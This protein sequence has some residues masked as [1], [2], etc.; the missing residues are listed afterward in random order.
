MIIVDD[1]RWV[2]D[3]ITNIVDWKSLGVEILASLAD[4]VDA[5][6]FVRSAERSP[7]I[8]L[9]DI[10]MPGM[11]GLELLQR[12]RDLAPSCH[13]IILSG[14]RDFEYARE[15]IHQ[16]VF[17]YVLKPVGKEEI[18]DVVRRL[19]A[20]LAQE[21]VDL[22]PPEAEEATPSLLVNRAIRYIEEH[23]TEP[24]GLTDVAAALL[25]SSA[26]LSSVFAETKGQ[27]FK[28]FLTRKKMQAAKEIWR[29]E[30][31]LRVYELCRRVGYRDTN[32]FARIFK[33]V[34][35]VTPR[36]FKAGAADPAPPDTPDG[37]SRA[38]SR[39]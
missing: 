8:C 14:Y 5:L 4:G 12:M 11:S 28:R 32:Y 6:D 39:S 3:G 38:P 34:E 27:T 19:T 7:D 20:L 21:R 22:A 31:Y 37:P 10:R 17:E 30:P 24:I 23:V 9:T 36:E 18:T 29:R 35:G 13:G 26:Y 15:A 25:V 2:R 16:G 1:E 33:Q